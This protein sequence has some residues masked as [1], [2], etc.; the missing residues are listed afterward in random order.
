[1]TTRDTRQC[2]RCAAYPRT[3]HALDPPHDCQH[4]LPCIVNPR[5]R[6]NACFNAR[7]AEALRRIRQS[8]LRAGVVATLPDAVKAFHR[9]PG[10]KQ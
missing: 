6:C 7:E 9:R 4:G 1:M 2:E 8:D 10:V 5:R 3:D